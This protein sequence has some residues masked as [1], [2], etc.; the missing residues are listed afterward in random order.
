MVFKREGTVI[1]QYKGKDYTG[2]YSI[3]EGIIKVHSVYGEKAT[4][5]GSLAPRVLAQMLLRE[6]VKAKLQK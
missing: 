3:D 2:F 6:L 1:I 4:Q 5:L